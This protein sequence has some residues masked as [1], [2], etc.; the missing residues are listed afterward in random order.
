[1]K[2]VRIRQYLKAEEQNIIKAY[3]RKKEKTKK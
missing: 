2:L 1:M 3:F